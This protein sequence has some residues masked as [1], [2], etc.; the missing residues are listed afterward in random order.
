MSYGKIAAA[1]LIAVGMLSSQAFAAGDPVRA[2]P[3]SRVAPFA[4]MSKRMAAM[5]LAPTCSDSQAANPLPSKALTIP[6]R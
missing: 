2:K 1:S 6:G 5:A 3:Y 4:T